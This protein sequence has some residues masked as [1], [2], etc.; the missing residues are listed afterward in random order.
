MYQTK[1]I[2]I[3]INARYT[4]L[5]MAHLVLVRSGYNDHLHRLSDLKNCLKR[6]QKEDGD[7]VDKTKALEICDAFSCFNV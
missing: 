5:E 1:V 3:L 2:F 6:I 4:Y 7:S